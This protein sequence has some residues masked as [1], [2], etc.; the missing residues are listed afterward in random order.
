MNFKLYEEELIKLRRHFHKHPE[1][2]F[3]EF[4]TTKYISKYMSKIGY[5]ITNLPETGLIANLKIDNSFPAIAIRCEIDALPINDE[6]ETDYRSVNKGA[7]HACGHDANIA[8]ALV[9]AKILYENKNILKKNIKFLFEPAEE[10]GGGAKYMIDNGA[11]E[12]PFVESFIM[13]HYSPGK[14]FGMS[15]HEKQASATVGNF[16]ITV[17][18]KASHWCVP[19]KGIDAIYGASKIIEAINEINKTSTKENPFIIGCG[20][21]SGGTAN[22]IISDKVKITGNLRAWRYEDYFNISEKLKKSI[23]N[24]DIQTGCKTDVFIRQDPIISIENNSFLISKAFET[25]KEIF[26][27]SCFIEK[28]KFLSGDNAALYFT[29]T[30]GILIVFLAANRNNPYPLHHP[31]VDLN[32]NNFIYAL[33]TLYKFILNIQ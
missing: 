25:G 6:I 22:N 33:E 29:K 2:A 12:N 14:N 31:K 23:S 28:Q 3:N 17:N 16:E 18:G 9:L 24:I 30:K 5:E 15:F 8:T 21:I 10:S 26:G 11:L 4:E 19:E 13:F 1:T 27:E 32:E 7:C 20:I